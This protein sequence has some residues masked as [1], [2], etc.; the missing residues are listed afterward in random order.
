MIKIKF[1]YKYPE[2]AYIR[3]HI[4]KN[5][6][7]AYNLR[8]QELVCVLYGIYNFQYK[9]KNLIKYTN[10]IQEIRY[11]CFFF[12]VV[13]QISYT[14]N[15]DGTISVSFLP[16]EAGDY[17]I[18]VRFGDKHIAGSPFAC[19]IEGDNKK[20]NQIS[21]GSCSQ[22]TLPGVLTDADLRTLNAI[23]V[24]P[25]GIEEPCFLKRLPSGNI[26]ISFTPRETGEHNVHVKRM[27]N[28]IKNS[29]FKINVTEKEVGNAKKVKTSGA[30]LKDGKTQTDN[31]FTID[32]RDAGYGGLSLSIEGPSKAQIK[33]LDQVDGTLQISYKPTAPGNYILNLKFADHHVEGSP[34]NIKVTG[35]GTNRQRENLLQQTSAV[36]SNDVGSKCKLTFKMPGITSFDLAASVTSPKGISQDAEVQEIEDGLYSVHFVPKEEGIHTISVKYT[37]IHIPGSPF[38]F[39]GMFVILFYQNYFIS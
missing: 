31:T 19:K 2:I 6:Y 17:N 37:D 25:S 14:D 13:E 8:I 18:S 11:N 23:I 3:E 29:P 27:G 15:K 34:F 36:P 20:R 7:Y 16:T 35:E 5:Y 22:V 1:H 32:T 38:Q 10:I 26:G 28:Q 4:F 24:T 9:I 21:I 39:T 33:C 30:T 12:V